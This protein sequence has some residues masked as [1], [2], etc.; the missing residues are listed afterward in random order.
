LNALGVAA[1]LGLALSG[2]STAIGAPT[3]KSNEVMCLDGLALPVTSGAQV[4]LDPDGIPELR[5]Q[6]LAVLDSTAPDPEITEAA[7]DVAR[8]MIV[9]IDT[10]EGLEPGPGLGLLGSGLDA[11]SVLGQPL[12]DLSDSHMGLVEA[13]SD[14]GVTPSPSVSSV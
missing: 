4:F 11:L 3:E 8:K 6:A 2:C 10:V 5:T 13:C 7:H 1:A 14:V 12:S 9:V